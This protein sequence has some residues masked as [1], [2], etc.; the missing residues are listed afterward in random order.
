MIRTPIGRLRVISILEGI[1][2]LVL[3]GIAM[4]LK[5]IF[6]QPEAVRV[7]GLIHGLLALLFFFAVGHVWSARRWPFTRV[8]HAL[9]ASVIPFGAFVLE[10][11][12]RREEQLSYDSTTA[13]ARGRGPFS[14]L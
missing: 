8:L 12:L 11:R 5:Y 3:L 1:S 2:F 7:V 10:A 4:P 13:G 14:E 6:D 9:V